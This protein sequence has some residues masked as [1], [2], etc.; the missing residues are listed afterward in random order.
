MTE[1]KLTKIEKNLRDGLFKC[2]ITQINVDHLSNPIIF[3][4]IPIIVDLILHICKSAPNAFLNAKEILQHIQALVS[5]SPHSSIMID[6][7]LKQKLTD[8]IVKLI[9]L[10]FEKDTEAFRV[11]IRDQTFFLQD[12]SSI[13]N[14]FSLESIEQELYVR[15]L[16]SCSETYKMDEKVICVNSFSKCWIIQTHMTVL[17]LKL[18]EE[19]PQFI[20]DTRMFEIL[21]EQ[22]QIGD[23]GV[24]KVSLDCMYA[25][26]KFV[27]LDP[28]LC[29]TFTETIISLL[30]FSQN[31]TFPFIRNKEFDDSL[32]KVLPLLSIYYGSLE[33]ELSEFFLEYTG[34]NLKNSKSHLFKFEF[35]SLYAKLISRY[36][37]MFTKMKHLLP[38]LQEKSLTIPMVE[39]FRHF[40]SFYL[41]NDKKR[42]ID[43]VNE[44]SVNMKMDVENDQF[45][46]FYGDFFAQTN[47]SIESMEI[48]TFM[49]NQ[50]KNDIY[51]KKEPDFQLLNVY[52]RIFLPFNVSCLKDL[53]HALVFFSKEINMNAIKEYS[54]LFL[55]IHKEKTFS[56]LDQKPMKFLYDFIADCTTRDENVKCEIFPLINSFPK[57]YL[58]HERRELFVEGLAD[59]SPNFRSKVL[60][61][62]PT[63]I[64]VEGWKSF[65]DVLS[66]LKSMIKDKSSEVLQ[67]LIKCCGKLINN[68]DNFSFSDWKPF[69]Q[70]L[71]SKVDPKVR[72]EL[73]KIIPTV[74]NRISE[75]EFEKNKKN[76]IE[77]FDHFSDKTIAV[78][79]SHYSHFI[80]KDEKYLNVLFGS[81]EQ[82]LIKMTNIFNNVMDIEVSEGV[83]VT[84]SRIACHINNSSF[85]R[86][87]LLFLLQCLQRDL[88][89]KMKS[90]NV[91][92]YN[93]IRSM[94][95]E[96]QCTNELLFKEYQNDIFH[97]IA[98]KIFESVHGKTKV[99]KELAETFVDEI[100][101]IIYEVEPQ[102]FLK[103]Y[104]KDIIP[105]LFLDAI[106]KKTVEPVR[107]FGDLIDQSYSSFLFEYSEYILTLLLL[108]SPDCKT[109]KANLQ[110]LIDEFHQGDGDKV[111]IPKLV[112]YSIS[113]VVCGLCWHLGGDKMERKNSQNGFKI[114]NELDSKFEKMYLINGNFNAFMDS[115][116]GINHILIGKDVPLSDKLQA[117]RA[118]QQVIILLGIDCRKFEPAIIVTL[119]R[120]MEDS[121]LRSQ[122]LDT[123]KIF[124][125]TLGNSAGYLINQV[126]A[127][128]EPLIKLETKKVVDIFEYLIIT[129]RDAFKNYFEE[130]PSLP[131]IPELADVHK[132]LIEESGDFTL[133]LK[134]EKKMKGIDNES[135]DV[136]RYTLVQL[137][138]L[139]DENENA[140]HQLFLQDPV[141]EILQVFTE[142]LL[143]HSNEK[144]NDIKYLCCQ[145]LGVLGAVEPTKLRSCIGEQTKDEYKDNL[146]FAVSLLNPVLYKVLISHDKEAINQSQYAVQEILKF[147][148][149]LSKLSF[150]SKVEPEWWKSF[151]VEVKEKF[152]PCR[153]S[154]YAPYD[155]PISNYE[156]TLI[157]Q[158]GQ[159]IVEWIKKW[160]R[161]LIPQA[162]KTEKER[163]KIFVYC[164]GLMDNLDVGLYILPYLVMHVAKYG[165][166]ENRES[167]KN[168]ILNV[169]KN[170]D[171]D[172]AHAQTVFHLIETMGKWTENTMNEEEISKKEIEA[173]KK[174]KALLKKIPKDV[175]ARSAMQNKAYNRAFMY[176]E[177]YL[178][179]MHQNSNAIQLTQNKQNKFE[180]DEISELHRIYSYLGERDGM[181]GIAT[182][183]SNTTLKEELI[184][185][186]SLGHWSNALKCCEIC[187]EENPESISY[188][189]DALESML[190][191]GH[192]Q[193]MI[194]KI[195]G[196]LGRLKPEES[197]EIKTYGV[198][199]AWRLGRW[200]TVE[201]YIHGATDE[202]EVGLAKSFLYYRENK[203][204]EFF[205]EIASTRKKI[206][207]PLSAASMESYHHSY[208]LLIKLKIL[209]ELE[210]SFHFFQNEN[211]KEL[212]S[213]FYKNWETSLSI[214][215]NSL[216]I[217][218]PILAVRQTVLNIHEKRKESD[219]IW[220]QLA[221]MARKTGYIQNCSSFLLRVKDVSAE[222]AI[223]KG[224]LLWD[225]SQPSKAISIAQ[226][227]VEKLNDNDPKKAKLMLMATNWNIQT[228]QIS[229]E[230]I[231]EMFKNIIA[232]RG[233]WEKGYYSLAKCID[234][235]NRIEP[236]DISALFSDVEKDVDQT[237][238]KSYLKVIPKM[239]KYYGLSLKY[240]H[241]HL[242]ESLPRLLT[243]WFD[244]TSYLEKYSL[245]LK[246]RSKSKTEMS[247][248]LNLIND[249]IMDI[250]EQ[251]PTYMW[252]TVLPQLVSR[253][254]HQ[255]QLV[256]NILFKIFVTIAQKYPKQ[257]LWSLASVR[258]S[259]I[260]ERNRNAEVL[261]NQHILS[262]SDSI[263]T[264][265]ENN[266]KLYE[267]L[268]S[269]CNW[270]PS[271]TGKALLSQF[272]SF[273]SIKKLLPLPFC[274][275]PI[276]SQLTA[277]L[278][279]KS[280][281]DKEEDPN[282]NPFDFNMITIENFEPGITI[283]SSLQRPKKIEIKGSDGE[284]YT[285]LCKPKDDL[286]KDNRM[287]E[288][289]SMVNRLLKSDAE[290]RKKKLCLRIY[291]VI[292]LNESTGLIEW[293]KHTATY[294][295]LCDEQY[296]IIG[297]Y[298]STNQLKNLIEKR[299]NKS[300]KKHSIADLMKDQLFSMFPPVFYKWFLQ[301]FT[302]PATWFQCRLNYSR[303]TAVAS[304]V[305]YIVGLGD[306]HGENILF[307]QHT[308]ECVQ[309]DFGML[310]EK[311]KTLSVKEVV[312]FRL[313]QNMVDAFGV[314]GYEGVFREVCQNTMFVLRNNK[315]TLMNVLETFVHDPLVEW[316]SDGNGK[317]KIDVVMGK[318]EKKLQGYV[319]NEDG[320]QTNQSE[321][322]LTIQ[323][324]VQKLI[325]TAT[326]LE[327]LGR[328]YP[329]WMP[330]L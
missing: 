68:T 214:T 21:C 155:A 116:S 316:D 231:S 1:L 16:P 119:K 80:V 56:I 226:S 121:Q 6:Q 209:R 124:L 54:S 73:V 122:S 129:Q 295:S 263:R 227:I 324:Q 120:S 57:Q 103:K 298:Q 280:E 38:F 281:E 273:K 176:Y 27:I 14:L 250:I 79:L 206:M 83:L 132:V 272:T 47:L 259:C 240:G 330:W 300:R 128:L 215:E 301:S 252:M 150:D 4:K 315:D 45:S 328:M 167:I 151:P 198:Q 30:K 42:K 175:L 131:E 87:V 261:I 262:K 136:R 160:T 140:L 211:P 2:Q 201:R 148:F 312:P 260:R 133:Q 156:S 212:D 174:V 85:M 96:R 232:L 308:G 43:T 251:I 229:F 196:L 168:E 318:I 32:S 90:I 297:Q 137:Y 306:R 267:M 197:T 219:A 285:F 69:F 33:P 117:L 217:R 171:K 292:P 213:L 191:L 277:S 238:G 50:I 84:I 270:T 72:M 303:T 323:G 258:F 125:V 274:I 242:Y 13:C 7:N 58:V 64:Q 162:V 179:E 320:Y 159:H 302:E 166:D 237:K 113:M 181:I 293:V 189:V 329:W 319:E 288:F 243:H 241:S 134:I 157:F 289:N 283:L 284:I 61:Q 276:Q 59:Y 282:H 126:I 309:I 70:L 66:I 46:L 127:D 326:S 287:M 102:I 321:V 269:L 247:T 228:Y 266:L 37:L 81:S 34:F 291:S 19:I 165:S 184:D 210:N 195:D 246:K 15:Y 29:N 244:S 304:M 65:S 154:L 40:V 169:L 39:I 158:K 180:N 91:I 97:M 106:T 254:C 23:S 234:N 76:F 311:G 163:A 257:L 52:I 294:R 142:K 190:N 31:E 17:Y 44:E 193:M 268:I 24:K 265:V 223:Q 48:F 239:L 203:K 186:Q 200:D 208:P 275:I 82:F 256:L 194:N 202:F 49:M 187:L 286:R 60:F 172:S 111:Q 278:P 18:L 88:D 143:Q 307:D 71:D 182:L 271:K 147:C 249:E 10:L 78:K 89:N 138:K 62:I 141:D 123:W 115:D 164:R 178:R 204:L 299:K 230:D 145:C 188:N 93:C 130:I 296:K 235:L 20:S 11:F 310:F 173:D 220:L 77:F 112:S 110:F 139:L 245:S 192:L 118:L 35:C 67:S 152:N 317:T 22:L 94:S 8:S 170:S 86:N 36:P 322:S 185:F 53:I 75:E 264:M 236:D 12:L 51:A 104:T 92:S 99:E 26:S 222:F 216:K 290:A 161:V 314:T 279:S 98:E 144:D 105:L 135:V 177:L 313:T 55:E 218:E 74:M 5:F 233:K 3:G 325:S 114:L 63:F 205:N 253:I 225:D 100:I 101:P 41:S 95:K 28:V 183:R 25:L 153:S 199:A 149:K 9:I 108:D 305:G 224:K 146:E 327:N 221:K 255:N 107:K 109:F 207:N 248:L